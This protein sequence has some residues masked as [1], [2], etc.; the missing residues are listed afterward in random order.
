MKII[1]LIL[2]SVAS[3]GLA[4]GSAVVLP[5]DNYQ[6]IDRVRYCFL[7]FV[8]VYEAYYFIGK[9]GDAHGDEACLKLVYQRNVS[10]ETLYKATR[11]SFIERHGA[12]VTAEYESVLKE[13]GESYV[14]VEKGSSYQF[15][16]QEKQGIL[17][18]A[19]NELFKIN[20][21]DFASR[22][23]QIWVENPL[24]NEPKWN[25]HDCS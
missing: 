14:D 25:F 11:K 20:A 2:L 6:L 12:Q 16:L 24:E 23:F 1:V 19:G 22:Y 8:P 5:G 13:I 18:H 7:P 21:A 4:Y 9:H 3:N 17:M 15:C 10:A